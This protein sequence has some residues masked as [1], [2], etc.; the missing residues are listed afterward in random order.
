[1]NKDMEAAS[2]KQDFEAAAKL[3][4]NIFSLE[5]IQ[6]VSLIGKDEV[7]PYTK[8]KEETMVMF[9]PETAAI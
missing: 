2:K 5:H 8:T 4:N 9:I 3:R 6:D 7:V 1:M